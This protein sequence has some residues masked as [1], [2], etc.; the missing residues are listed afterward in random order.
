[1]KYTLKAHVCYFV[2]VVW[3]LHYMYSL[4]AD[5]DTSEKYN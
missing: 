3:L 2:L 1:M 5:F 4:L